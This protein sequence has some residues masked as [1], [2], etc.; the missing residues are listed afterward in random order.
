MSQEKLQRNVNIVYLIVRGLSFR[1]VAKRYRF[2]SVGTVQEI[3]KRTC[4]KIYKKRP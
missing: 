4:D 1:E 3:Y 2:K